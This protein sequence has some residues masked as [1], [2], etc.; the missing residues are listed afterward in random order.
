MIKY[1]L[2]S[3]NATIIFFFHGME[4]LFLMHFQTLNETRTV[5]PLISFRIKNIDAHFFVLESCLQRQSR[6]D[7]FYLRL[8]FAFVLS[9]E[10]YP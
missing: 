4:L 7:V 3:F 6:D 2:I 1:L 9:L 10:R 8:P 5:L